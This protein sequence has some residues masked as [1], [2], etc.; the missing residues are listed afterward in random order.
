L[1]TRPLVRSKCVQGEKD[2]DA[3]EIPASIP[4]AARKAMLLVMIELI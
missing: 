1:S 4:N 2:A 3:G